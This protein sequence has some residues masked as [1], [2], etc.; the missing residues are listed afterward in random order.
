VIADAVADTGLTLHFALRQLALQEPA[1]LEACVLVDQ[2][3]RRLV[4]DLP[5]R[6]S[7]AVR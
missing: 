2:R 7:A 1:T 4:D 3:E 5:L 6:G